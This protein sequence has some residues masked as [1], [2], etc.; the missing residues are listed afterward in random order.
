MGYLNGKFELPRDCNTGL[1]KSR[2]LSNLGLSFRNFKTRMW[3]Q[4]SQKDKM[5]DW[6]KYPLLKPYWSGFKKY[7]QPEEA[8]KISQENKINTKK[9]V[10]HYTT[11]SRGYTGKEETGQE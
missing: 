9:K 1:V 10:I 2:T 3:T 7:K 4:Y 8:T 5:I 6:D 11:G